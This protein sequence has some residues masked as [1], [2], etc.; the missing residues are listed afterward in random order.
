M[1]PTILQSDPAADPPPEQQPEQQPEQDPPKMPLLDLTDAEL[2]L[3][4]GPPS[5]RLDQ[6]KRWLYRAGVADVES[7]T[8]VPTALRANLAQ[9]RVG[10]L[11]ELECHSGDDGMTVRWLYDAAG[12]QVETVLLGYPKRVTV[13]VSSQA[14]CAM[15][16]QFC[17]TG[18]S[19]FDRH[20]S[21]GEILEQVLRARRWLQGMPQLNKQGLERI[22]NVVFMGMGEPL[23]NYDNFV[24]A[25]LRL[26]Q[27]CGIAGRAITV[28]TIGIPDRIRSLPQDVPPITLA[29]SLHAPDDALRTH[30]VPANARWPIEA[31]ISAIQDYRNQ[32]G[33]RVTIE[34]TLID[35]IN[36]RAEHAIGVARIAARL[37]AHVNCISQNP[38]GHSE[39]RKPAAVAVAQFMSTLKRHGANATLRASRAIDIDGA[40]GQLRLRHNSGH[41]AT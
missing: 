5:Y 35:Q 6:V 9:H 19:G 24:R 37:G 2:A 25:V 20:L 4:I 41:F 15:G 7:M 23:A 38:I 8:D 29:W 17:A 40:C 11:A 3:L 21:V 13:C 31:V 30:L 1:R 12:T 39:F 14:G 18:R 10:H 33:R 32:G 28:S 26:N 36:D 34:Y 16:C 27:D 22:G